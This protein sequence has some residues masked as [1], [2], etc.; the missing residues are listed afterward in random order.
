M[1]F[2]T[3]RRNTKTRILLAS[4]FLL[5]IVFVRLGIGVITGEIPVAGRLQPLRRVTTSQPMVALTFDISWGENVPT[6]VLD[7]LKAQGVHSTFF[8][9]GPWASTH[10]DIVRRIVSEKH[11]LASHGWKHVNYSQLSR[12]DI[13][14]NIFQAHETLQQ[15]T[16]VSP[17]LIRTPNGDYNDTV[18]EVATELGYTVVEWSLDSLDWKKP[19]VDTIVSRVVDRAKPGD[20]ILMHASD[21]AAQTPDALPAVIDGLRAKGLQL[22][23]V[24]EL[25][26]ASSAPH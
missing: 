16:G 21:T 17:H 15:I 4:G 2:V 1:L 12:E 10:Q 22:V 14:T 5:A 18:I 20:I 23:T 26:S 13:R 25:L 3:L 24:G 19:G 6:P 9:S 8:I 7:I 11:E